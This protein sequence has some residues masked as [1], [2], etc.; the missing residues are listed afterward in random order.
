MPRAGAC[1]CMSTAPGAAPAGRRLEHSM[2]TLIEHSI[3]TL[4]PRMED[5]RAKSVAA[6][7]SQGLVVVET[8]T[9][10][11]DGLLRKSGFRGAL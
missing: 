3:E 10:G 11:Q 4:I 9:P 1:G 8:R 2:E 5:T 6:D 7:N